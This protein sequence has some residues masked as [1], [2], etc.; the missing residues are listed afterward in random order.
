[1]GGNVGINEEREEKRREHCRDYPL[2][3]HTIGPFGEAKRENSPGEYEAP[4]DGW[5]PSHGPR[6]KMVP[7]MAFFV[8]FTH[9]S[10]EGTGG[11]GK[12]EHRRKS[13]KLA[14]K[15]ERQV[16]EMEMAQFGH[17]V[18]YVRKRTKG[19]K[20]QFDWDDDQYNDHFRQVNDHCR[21]GDEQPILGPPS[22][23]LCIDQAPP[24]FYLNF[25]LVSLRMFI[26][27]SD[28][29]Y[30]QSIRGGVGRMFP[31]PRRCFFHKTFSAENS[32]RSIMIPPFLHRM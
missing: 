24:N 8:L 2:K 31:L 25:V 9:W 19:Q 5:E 22:L 6:A 21:D 32:S 15:E 30:N 4:G 29:I 14:K 12:Y 23:Y 27:R 26:L 7:K 18:A 16:P 17:C 1:M 3:R 11:V 13:A 20:H 28:Q 10:A